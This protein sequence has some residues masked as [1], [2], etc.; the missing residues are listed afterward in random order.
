MEVESAG[1]VTRGGLTMGGNVMSRRRTGNGV[2]GFAVAQLLLTVLAMAVLLPSAAFAGTDIDTL[3]GGNEPTT[4]AVNPRSPNIIA[5]ARGL[6]AAISTDFGRSFPTTVTMPQAAPNPPVYGTIATWNFCGD[7]SVAFDS[8]GRLFMTYLLCGNNN[9]APPVRVDVSAFVQQI[10]MTPGPNFGTL[11]GMPNPVEVTGANALNNDDKEWIAA[12]A[13]PDSPFRDN[14]YVVWTRLGTPNQVMFSRSTDSGANWSAPTQINAAGEGF[15]WPSHIAVAQNG[16][17]YITYHSDTCNGATPPMFVLR[18]SSGG[19]QFQAGTGFQKTSFVS[20]VSCNQRNLSTAIPNADFWMQGAN[21]GFV[22]PDPV[23]PGNVYVVVDDDPND[24]FTTGDAAEVKLARSTDFGQTWTVSTISHAPPAQPG[25]AGTLQ[26]YPT[27]AIDQL[28]NLVVTWWDTRRGFTNTTGNL[29]LDQYATVSR[30]GGLTFTNDFRISDRPFDPDLNAPCRFGPAALNCGT[31]TAAP[32]TFRIGEY[33]G[34]AAANGTAY[35]IWTGNQ[36]PPNPQATP[37]TAAAGNQT[38]YFD[39][40]TILGAFPDALEPNDSWDPG[41]ASVLGANGTYLQHDLT[42]HSDTDED[43]FKVTA[44]STGELFFSINYNS[45]FADLDIQVRDKFNNV[46]RTSTAGLDTNNTESISIPAVAGE[47][48]FVRVFA[49]PGQVPPINTYDLG[50]VNTPAPVPFGLVLA[51]GSD[52]G[53]SSSDNI[54]NN[55][56]P[57]ILLVVDLNPLSALSFSPDDGTATLADDTPGYKVEIY[58]NGIAAGRA[59]P[60]A[61]QPGIFTFTFT[62]PLTIGPNFITARVVIVDNSDNAAVPGT[63]HAVGQGGESGGL[64]VTFD[65][66]APGAAALGPLD[67]LASSDSGGI[68]D[69]NITTFSTPSFSIQVNEPGFVRIFAARLP[70]GPILQVAQFQATITGA[71]QV[72]VQS[73]DD[74]VYNMTATIEDVAGNVGPPTAPLRV[75]IAKFSLTLPGLTVTTAT[76]PVMI[77]LAAKTIQGFASAS[78]TGL[79]GISGIPTVNVDVNGQILTVNLTAGDDSLA[80]T[81]F[82]PDS[83]S[84]A[85]AGVNQVISFTSSGVFT[86]NPLGGNDTVTTYGTAAGDLVN[87]TV[88][89]TIA[90]QVGSALSLNMPAAQIEKVGI[91]TAQGNDT[92]NVNIHDTVNASLFV[93]GGEPTTVNKGNDVLNLVDESAGRKGTYSNISGGSTPGAGAVVLTFKAT[94]KATRVDYVGIEKQTR[95]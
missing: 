78:A 63:L 45:R 41:V 29:L 43:W 68:N 36:T 81:P 61:G 77:D 44:L 27:G 40:F 54:T 90:V 12:D 85:L 7:A 50:I 42:I 53:S 62:S 76:T 88:D 26:V 95:K 69:D 75:T 28:G 47:D 73:L 64:L 52:T 11:N 21:Q 70:A 6:T 19:A 89:T 49:E 34:T 93:D 33:N 25:T 94:G 65:P 4:A 46:V 72:T 48:Y 83:G 18:D 84:I 10:N 39:A 17:V 86:V 1:D 55:G 9:A 3:L 92:I 30:D 15:V 87:V 58:R 80:Y 79:I 38:T 32:A 31:V 67:L 51:P 8:Q 71:W 24:N 5:V 2:G 22:I 59:T 20:G 82:T 16:D 60:V 14:L 35:V 13:N 56:T 57:T 91:S 23:R 74:G 37:P 66:T